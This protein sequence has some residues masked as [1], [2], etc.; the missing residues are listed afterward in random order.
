MVLSIFVIFYR[1]QRVDWSLFS[2]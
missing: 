2:T 1:F